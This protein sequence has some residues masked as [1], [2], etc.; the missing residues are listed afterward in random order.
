MHCFITNFAHLGW[1]ELPYSK[2]V[3]CFNRGSAGVHDEC[4][5]FECCIGTVF[6][7]KLQVKFRLQIALKCV[8][9]SLSV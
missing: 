3:L 1:R 9:I 4:S 5:P 6:P 8:S 2:M 7:S